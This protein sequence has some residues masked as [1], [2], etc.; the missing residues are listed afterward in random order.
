MISRDVQQLGYAVVRVISPTWNLLTGVHQY[1][2]LGY[3]LNES[4]HLFTDVPHPF[5]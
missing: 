2:F 1:P 4:K 5:P 3:K